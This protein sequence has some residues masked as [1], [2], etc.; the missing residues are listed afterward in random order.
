MF[1]KKSTKDSEYQRIDPE[2]GSTKEPKEPRKPEIK[3][4]THTTKPKV[5]KKSNWF[6]WFVPLLLCSI[7]IGFLVLYPAPEKQPEAPTK[8]TKVTTPIES[9]FSAKSLSNELVS[10]YFNGT[11]DDKV[12]QKDALEKTLDMLNTSTNPQ[13][14]KVLSE[15]QSSN[16]NGAKK[17]LITLAS[18]QNNLQESSQSWVDIGN[19]QN[20]SSSRQALQAY[21]KA[22]DIDP[23]NIA[24]YSRQGDVYRQLKQFNLAE[25]AYKRVQSFANQSTQNQALTL[26]NFG[27]LNVSKG[28]LVEA[29]DAFNESLSI[30]K[31]IQDDAGIANISYQLANLYKDSERFEQADNYYKTAL[32]TFT[33]SDEFKKMADTHA[34]MGSMYQTMQQKIKAQS[35]LELAL[36]IN[37]NNNFDDSNP[38]IYQL[39]GALAEENGQTEKARAY[40][41]RA[42]GIDPNGAQDNKVADELGKQA[43]INRKNRNFIVA[44]EQHKQAIKIYQQNKSIA[45]TISQQINLGFL[46]KVW[47]KIDLA[48]LVWRDTLT[49]SQRANSNRVG[50]VQQLVDTSCI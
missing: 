39:L 47:G 40:F 19:I 26:A 33:K 7:A 15:L 4:N 45:G 36:E 8:I 24:A 44:E 49:I 46:Y 6:N 12:K 28:K 11:D 23:E 42:N 37:T 48:C 41:A 10:R 32:T 21:K 5:K 14:K 34:A 38:P 2:L 20:L 35:H 9:V 3:V 25:K 17:S 1:K 29:E 16:I 13:A 31:K 50:R 22:S 30:Y 18:T 43:I 27:M